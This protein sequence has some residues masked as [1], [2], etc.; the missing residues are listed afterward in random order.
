MA[1]KTSNAFGKI[2]I[3]N[4][5]IA[6]VTGHIARDCYGVV[7]LAGQ[8]FFGSFNSVKKK[9]TLSNGVKIKT[10]GNR[11]YIDLNV[12]LK[13]GVSISTVTDNLKTSIKYGV[14][15]FTGMIIDSVNINVVGVRV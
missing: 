13:F 12:I 7:D 8:G 3:D 15:S 11:I 9:K 1:V 14:E 10:I 4:E 6:C 5:A 2:T